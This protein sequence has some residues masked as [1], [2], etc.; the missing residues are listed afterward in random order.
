MLKSTD[1]QKR[2]KCIRSG[3]WRVCV[4][5]NWKWSICPHWRSYVY[6]M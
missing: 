3:N 6:K 4:Y 2:L 5:I 1:K